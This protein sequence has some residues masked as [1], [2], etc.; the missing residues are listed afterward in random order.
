MISYNY[1][2]GAESE[3]LHI[4]YDSKVIGLEPNG[5]AQD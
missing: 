1:Y 4:P 3:K 2:T 5:L